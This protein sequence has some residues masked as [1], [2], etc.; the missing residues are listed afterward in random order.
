[1][2]RA[3]CMVVWTGLAS[4]T[5]ACV[6]PFRGSNVQ[7]DFAPAVHTP[8]RPGMPPAA[9]QPPANTYYSLYGVDEVLGDSGAVS[10]VFLFELERFEVRPLVDVSSPCFLE[11]EGTPYPGLH[12]SQFLSRTAADVGFADPLNPPPGADPQDVSRL[13][14]AAA[15]VDRIAALGGYKVV[16]STEE[17]AYPAVAQQCVDDDPSSPPAAIP[18]PRCAG[19]LANARRLELCSQFWR[20]HPDVFEGSDR[21]LTRPLAG[22]FFGAVTGVNPVTSAP[23]GG[24]SMFVD[25]VVNFDAYAINWQYKNLDGVGGP[26]VPPGGSASPV[27]TPYMT[28]RP[29]ARTRGV[30]NVRLRHAMNPAIAAEMAVFSAL[31]DDDVHF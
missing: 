15:R 3:F 22:T 1:M 16:T 31:G 19:P 18:P 20:A 17:V 10:Q 29:Q 13:L 24:T 2:K 28:G 14:T 8:A 4:M 11:P 6:E 12:A 30:V 9:H 5:T 25:E 27:G 21:T 23:T 7:I 26:D